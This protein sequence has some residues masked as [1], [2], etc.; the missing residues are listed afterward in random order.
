MRYRKL[1]PTGDYVF[2][3]GSNEFLV[4]SPEAVGQAVKTRLGL[5]SGEWFLDSQEGTP[6]ATQIL[7]EGT[8]TLYDI[9]I[10]NRI[11]GTEGVTSIAT[12]GSYLSPQ[13]ALTVECTINTLYGTTTVQQS[14]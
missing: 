1:S 11:L 5:A 7:G 3:Q 4:N 14:L 9:A 6:Y 13:R 8:Q 2:G 10:Q 12:Y